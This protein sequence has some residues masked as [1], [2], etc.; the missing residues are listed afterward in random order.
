MKKVLLGLGLLLVSLG[1]FGQTFEYKGMLYNGV[2]MPTKVKGSL[3]FTDTTVVDD[4]RV[5]YSTPTTMTI[6]ERDGD[7]IR[8]FSRENESNYYIISED[9]ITLYTETKT[10]GVSFTQ[11]FTYKLIK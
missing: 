5:K 10:T 8:I 9:V 4:M 1:M 11:T 7:K 2:K 6:K 3:T